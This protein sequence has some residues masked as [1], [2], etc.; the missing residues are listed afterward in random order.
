MNGCDDSLNKHSG[1]VKPALLT[2]TELQWLV[3]NLKVSPDYERQIRSRIN[4][5]IWTFH[6]CE[7]RLLE[8]KGF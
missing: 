5:K 1:L 8:E 7:M 6:N 4:R 2:K 3:G